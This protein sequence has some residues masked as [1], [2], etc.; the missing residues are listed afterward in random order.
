MNKVAI[1]PG[2]FDPITYGHIDVIKKALKLFDKIIV[3]VSD[4]SNKNYLF[5]SEERIN[6]VNKALFNDLK[7]N[8]KKISVV[9]FSSLTTD[10]CK[11]YK[12]NII[13]RGLRAVSDFEYEFQLAGMNRKLNNNIE[14]IFLMSDVE[15]QII[16][17]RFVKEIVKLNGDIRKFTT[18]STIKSL[19]EKYE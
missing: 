5:N 8:K 11:K 12:S 18:K 6:I 15:N 1:Y 14:T 7:L 13:L 4:V 19:K 16:S 9:S 3:G 10:L 17:S 2:T